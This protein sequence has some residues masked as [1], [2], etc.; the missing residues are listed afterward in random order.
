MNPRRKIAF[1]VGVGSLLVVSAS[2]AFAQPAIANDPPDI[3]AIIAEPRSEM[4][5]VIRRFEAD[6]G[7][8]SRAYWSEASTARRDRLARFYDGWMTAMDA[9]PFD[10][11]SLD[12]KVDYTLLKNSIARSRQQLT[13]DDERLAEAGPFAPFAP[14]IAELAD[15]RRKL[16]PMPPDQAATR[17]NEL[18]KQ[19]DAAK[20]DFEEKLKPA[21]ADASGTPGKPSL[22]P[23][24]SKRAL[25]YIESLRGTLGEWYGFFN[26]YDPEFTW[27]NAE[28]YRA[29]DAAL[30]SYAKL[31]REK[32]VGIT[33]DNPNVIVGTPIGR[34]AMLAELKFEM[35]PYTPEELIAIAER[36]FA[37]CAVELK[38]ASNDMGLGDDWKQA[39]EKVKQTHL[40]PGEQP[41]LIRD[42]AV[43][44]VAFLKEQN[45][46]T[47]PPL[48]EE[49]WRMEMMTP[50]R[51][52]V[53]PFFTGGEVV[54][55]S[56]PVASMA[57]EQKLMSLRGN[58][59][60]FSRATVF[61]ELIPG[62][63]LQ[64]F[65]NRRAKP[66]RSSFSTPFWT[67]GWALY[68]EMQ[69]WDHHF[70]KSPENRIG[71]LFWRSH[72][73]ARIIFSI[74]YQLG[75][76]S[77]QECID[78]L[79]D[80]VGHERANAEGEVRRSVS[81]GYGPLYQVAYMIGGLQFRALH[82]ELVGSGKMTDRD[83]HDAVL[84]E[85]NIPIEMIRAMLKK[86]PPPRNFT[87][88]WRFDD[89]NAPK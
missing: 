8:L 19:V 28:P 12:G 55:V 79:V 3:S 50:E 70:P 1:G 62:H 84:R 74:K 22:T 59:I 5:E 32:G 56:F 48:A 43:E 31:V 77:P 54:S 53:T 67:E 18:K 17:L 14:I 80:R 15:S 36:E 44:A 61:H 49:T 25:D 86:E 16:E 51:Q 87:T 26:G 72:R 83:F 57:H 29:A 60:H 4:A 69:M 64:Q 27:W 7:A 45:L 52:L 30:D 78:F 75:E 9:V 39:L 81:G 23:T 21:P 11:L 40:K 13:R 42:L 10:T 68:W 89:A 2:N 76:M 46:L 6:E 63:H 37:W 41:T 24:T 71:M 82:K 35:I 65:A 66:H 58:N 47:I 88:S 38:K 20:K 33:A 85:H 34:E 73:C